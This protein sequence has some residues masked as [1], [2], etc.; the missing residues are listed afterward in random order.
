ME[1]AGTPV[2]STAAS[3][4]RTR[5]LTAWRTGCSELRSWSGGRAG[6]CCRERAA[7][8]ANGHRHERAEVQ[9]LAAGLVYRPVAETVVDELV[10]FDTISVMRKKR[11][12][13]SEE[14]TG[15]HARSA[16][17]LR[18]YWSAIYVLALIAL[19]A[20]TLVVAAGYLVVSLV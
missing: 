2:P 15:R 10:R 13:L 18:D 17:R 8:S 1:Q 11:D 9:S 6:S 16:W 7:G 4:P 3:S 5:S 12:T 19:V 20:V 14:S